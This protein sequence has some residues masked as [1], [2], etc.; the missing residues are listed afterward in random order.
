MLFF[1]LIEKVGPASC[2]PLCCI[3]VTFNF[4]PTFYFSLCKWFGTEETRY[5]NF[6][7]EMLFHSS[8]DMILAQ[9]YKSSLSYRL[10]LKSSTVCEAAEQRL[11]STTGAPFVFKHLRLQILLDTQS[12]HL[13]NGVWLMTSQKPRRC[14]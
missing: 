1:Y 11:V 12:C 13:Q 5:W 4:Y 10:P 6:K 3:T 9:F 14:C 2:L 8:L 7:S